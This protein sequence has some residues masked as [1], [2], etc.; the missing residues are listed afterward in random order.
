MFVVMGNDYPAAV[1]S[2]IGMAETFC[3]YRRK[4]DI[5]KSRIHWRVYE[6]TLDDVPTG[7]IT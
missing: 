6:F 5:N 2:T 1:F 4:V 3:E 7:R